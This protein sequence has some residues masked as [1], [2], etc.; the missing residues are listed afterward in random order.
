MNMKAKRTRRQI[1]FYTQNAVKSIEETKNKTSTYQKKLI[2]NKLA[3][4]NPSQ[5]DMS[6]RR[7]KQRKLNMILALR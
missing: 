6:E 7:A 3:K 5:I 4:I 1:S 2:V